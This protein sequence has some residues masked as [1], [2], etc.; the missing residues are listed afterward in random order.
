MNTRKTKRDE[1][2]VQSDAKSPAKKS[3][4]ASFTSA[5]LNFGKKHSSNPGLKVK[6]PNSRS[7]TANASTRDKRPESTNKS[8]SR[9]M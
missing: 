7:S 4:V 3:D 2:S 8:F 5:A 1:S 6:P 9:N